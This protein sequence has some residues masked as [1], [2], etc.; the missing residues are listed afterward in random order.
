MRRRKPAAESTYANILRLVEAA[1][2]VKAPMSRL[3]DR[4]AMAF[5]AFT[6]TLAGGAWLATGDERRL[7]AV[8]VIA[9]PC[10]LILAVPAALIAGLSRAAKHGILVKG[11][12]ALEALARARVLILDKT[13]TLT[14]GSTTLAPRFV[15]DGITA[16]EALRLAASLDQASNHV[17]AQ[18]LVHLAQGTALALSPPS[19]VREESGAGI[20]G[21]VEGRDVAVGSLA[22]L[23]AHAET[24]AALDAAVHRRRSEPRCNFPRRPHRRGVRDRRFRSARKRGSRSRS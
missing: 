17:V 4:Y 21:V 12:G 19:A 10:P 24:P 1:Q 16:D 5:L 6:V 20:E 15:A 23:K 22:F 8:L 2:R 3:A 14:S 11:G 9:T 18:L 13:G 7:L